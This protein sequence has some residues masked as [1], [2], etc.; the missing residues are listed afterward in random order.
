MG[1]PARFAIEYPQ[2][3][4][5]LIGMLEEPARKCDLLG[6]FGLLAAAAILTIPYERMRASHFLH[7]EKRDVDLVKHFKKL[8]KVKFFQA[9]FWLAA[10][11]AAAWR[12]ARIVNTVE[13]V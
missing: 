6:S 4:L 8:D 1:V 2:R 13:D 12:Q 10:P 11:D 5:E 7:N 3:A 9:P